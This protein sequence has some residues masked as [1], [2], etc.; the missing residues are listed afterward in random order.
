LIPLKGYEDTKTLVIFLTNI[1]FLNDKSNLDYQF[2]EILNLDFKNLILPNKLIIPYFVAQKLKEERLLILANLKEFIINFNSFEVDSIISQIP[3]IRNLSL[4][5][6]NSKNENDFRKIQ[7]SSNNVLIDL[8]N[9]KKNYNGNNN[10]KINGILNGSSNPILNGNININNDACFNSNNNQPLYKQS[11]SKNAPAFYNN[12]SNYGLKNANNNLLINNMNFK[13]G[14]TNLNN[15]I[16]NHNNDINSGRNNLEYTND[17]ESYYEAYSEIGVNSYENVLLSNRNEILCRNPNNT[18]NINPHYLLNNQS[19]NQ[20]KIINNNI[21]NENYFNT[22]NSQFYHNNDRD[23]YITQN[24]NFNKFYLFDSPEYYSPEINPCSIITKGIPIPLR[25]RLKNYVKNAEGG[26][27]CRNHEELHSQDGIILE[28]M[29]RAG[30]QLLEGKNMVGLSL[31]VKIFEPRST[32]TRLTDIWGTAYEYL[33]KA[34]EI[35]D[36]VERIK[37]IITMAISGLHLNTKQTKPFNP[38][39]GET[40]EVKYLFGKI[41]LIFLTYI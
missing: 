9:N 37:I 23:I 4:Q 11:I 12:Q 33:N 40:Y 34:A 41:F 32:L 26:V 13:E 39:L 38:I 25:E 29:K 3:N 16:T 5:K 8:N 28:L 2:S 35:G 30:K 10:Y 1:D 21:Q 19:N 18:L 15:N 24:N 7:S 22:S 17:Q 31:P 36:P 20:D 6:A 14:P 27:E